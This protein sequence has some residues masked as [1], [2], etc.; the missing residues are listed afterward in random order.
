MGSKQLKDITRFNTSQNLETHMDHWTHL[1]K[2]AL[3]NKDLLAKKGEVWASP[4]QILERQF[5]LLSDNPLSMNKMENRGVNPYI[6]QVA[7][8]VLRNIFPSDTTGFLLMVFKTSIICK[9][10]IC[11]STN[12]WTSTVHMANT[13]RP[14]ISA[15]TCLHESYQE[16]PHN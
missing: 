2:A 10:I 7:V 5:N 4:V 16:D 14:A 13:R 3:N 9:T 15:N 6:Y 12:T 1:L 11:S 8:R